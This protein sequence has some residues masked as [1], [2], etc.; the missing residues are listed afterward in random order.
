MIATGPD[1]QGNQS[2]WIGINL[3]GSF[4]E[5]LGFTST[6]PI[7]MIGFRSTGLG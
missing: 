3:P 7:Q 6:Q 4:Q 2:L 1:G 5:A